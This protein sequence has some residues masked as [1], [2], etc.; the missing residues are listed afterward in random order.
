MIA[1]SC[2]WP[3]SVTT[4]GGTGSSG[5]LSKDAADVAEVDDAVDELLLL[6]PAM[7]RSTELAATPTMTRIDRFAM[8]AP[9]PGRTL[10]P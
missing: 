5:A 3:M 6:Q 9:N 1:S 7:P 2:F 10:K 8:S 4:S